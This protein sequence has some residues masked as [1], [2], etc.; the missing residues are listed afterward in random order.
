MRAALALPILAVPA[1]AGAAEVGEAGITF[2][3]YKERGLMKVTEPVAWAHAQFADVWEAQGSGALD[4]I[5]GASPRIVTNETGKPM[6]T[7]T[8]A[9][10]VDHRS[11]AEGKL[12]RHFGD[13]ALSASG[14]YSSERDYR[15]KALGLEARTDLNEKLTT[16]TA[17]F[18][19][20]SDVVG[21]SEDVTLHHPR[22]TR[23]FMAGITQV[24]SQTAVL[25]STVVRSLGRGWYNDPY[26]ITLT[27]F[28]SGLPA[29]HADVRPDHRASVSWLTR[30][31]QHFPG[32]NGTLQA[33]YRFYRDDW[34]VRAHTLEVA[35]QQS[36]DE[37]WSI[38]PAL[39]YYTQDAASFYSPEVPPSRPAILSSDQ[40]LGAWG[41]LSPSL[42]AIVHL[43]GD[44][45]V[46]ATAGY[47]YNSRNLRA[48]GNGAEAFVTLRAYYGI[49]GISRS[50]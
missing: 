3:G 6:Q 46:E 36:I 45:T 22:G 41:G 40:R 14:A 44:L 16:L 37:R 38:R 1:K 31:R 29:I 19:H 33:D 34:G 15:S 50:F 43:D 10:V 30:Y 4:I 7:L 47:V 8:G 27:F 48:G 49:I 26:K 42:R 24:L 23:E 5:S 39:R 13:S 11:T 32:A 20:S 21:S 25:Q 9:S 18:G 28:P 12:T 35:W 17:G 2:L